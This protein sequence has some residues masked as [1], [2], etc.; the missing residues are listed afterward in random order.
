MELLGKLI[1]H[2]VKVAKQSIVDKMHEREL[3]VA[4]VLQAPE[5]SFDEHITSAEA[6]KERHEKIRQIDDFLKEKRQYV[7]VQECVLAAL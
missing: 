4:E 7:E 6:S 3:Y 2:R 1:A 5:E